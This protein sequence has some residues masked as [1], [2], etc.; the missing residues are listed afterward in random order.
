MDI[1]VETYSNVQAGIIWMH[2]SGKFYD[3]KENCNFIGAH[4]IDL[5]H[6]L[7]MGPNA[8]IIW[9]VFMS[10]LFIARYQLLKT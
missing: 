8:S 9:H 7:C 6:I 3:N 4:K 10:T 1:F 5:A 2:E